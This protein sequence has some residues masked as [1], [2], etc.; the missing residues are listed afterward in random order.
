MRKGGTSWSFRIGYL[1]V[2]DGCGASCAGCGVKRMV[3]QPS[4]YLVTLEFGYGMTPYSYVR[5][6]MN[7]VT[8]LPADLDAFVKAHTLPRQASYR[9]G[10]LRASEAPLGIC[11]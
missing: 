2:K 10:T 4:G 5:S 11:D 3:S 8:F 9:V 7:V 1:N 6:Q